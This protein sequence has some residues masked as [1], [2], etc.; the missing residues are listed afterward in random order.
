MMNRRTRQAALRVLLL[1]EEFSA[2]ELAEA[3]SLIG[4]Q[5]GE[6]LLAYLGRT[7][8]GPRK[9]N[10]SRSQD[11][12]RKSHGET[13]ALQEMKQTDPAKYEMLR[14]F[15]T[16]V[17]EGQVLRSMDDF[18]AFGK[19]LGK[20]FTPGKSRKES[21][22]RLM[23]VLAQMDLESIRAAIIKVPSGTSAEQSAFHRLANQIISGPANHTA[24]NTP[25][26]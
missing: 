12:K 15:E 19:V 25:Q 21:I 3:V 11:G 13:R 6:D 2:E 10:A 4:G 8:E 20:D 1:V 16:L 26:P 7:T 17:R 5:E 22:G 23:A 9:P 14:E 24:N 18:R